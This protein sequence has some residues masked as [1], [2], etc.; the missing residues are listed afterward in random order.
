MGGRGGH[1]DSKS[2]LNGKVQNT[3]EPN[4]KERE[5]ERERETVAL[6]EFDDHGHVAKY[7]SNHMIDVLI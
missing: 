6:T 5:R 4:E 1:S 3:S 2:N 7:I